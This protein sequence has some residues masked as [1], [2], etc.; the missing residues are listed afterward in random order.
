MKNPHPPPDLVV[1]IID[2]RTARL[3]RQIFIPVGAGD[4]VRMAD[5]IVER[6]KGWNDEIP[7]HPPAVG[8][9]EEG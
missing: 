1:Q 7:P 2:R 8:P 4:P 5:L 6:V 3:Y 9:P